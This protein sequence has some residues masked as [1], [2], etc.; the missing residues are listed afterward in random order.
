MSKTITSN[1]YT[2]TG[3]DT[4]VNCN[5]ISGAIVV[6]MPSAREYFDKAITF[7]KTDNTTNTAT[8]DGS[9]ILSFA[10]NYVTLRS[11]G[12]QW[13]VVDTNNTSSVVTLEDFDAVGDGVTNDTEAYLKAIAS[14]AEVRLKEDATYLIDQHSITSNVKITG[15]N[16]TLKCSEA[17]AYFI[18]VSTAVTSLI[19]DG[20]IIDANN[21]NAKCIYIDNADNVKFTNCTFKNA[22]NETEARTAVGIYIRQVTNCVIRDCL[23]TDIEGVPDTVIGNAKGASRGIE[24]NAFTGI[25]SRNITIENNI[26]QN[27]TQDEDGDGI[28]IDFGSAT[29]KTDNANIKIINNTFSNCQ[30]R[31]VKLLSPVGV[32]IEKNSMI[33]D[34]VAGMFSAIGL[35]T[36][37]NVKIV[38][39]EIG[40]ELY[41]TVIETTGTC[42]DV[43]ISN[44]I[45]TPSVE[46]NDSLIELNATSLADF[47]ISNNMMSGA[48]YGVRVKVNATRVIIAGNNMHSISSIPIYIDNFGYDSISNLIITNNTLHGGTYGV[49]VAAGST[50]TIKNNYISSSSTHVL[51]TDGLI[52]IDTDYTYRDRIEIFDDFLGFISGA[53]NLKVGTDGSAKAPEANLVPTGGE[54]VFVTGAAGTGVAADGSIMVGKLPVRTSLDNL[55]FEA[56]VKINTSIAN[57]SVNIGFT[58]NSMGVALEEPFTI[59][60]GDAITSNATDACCFVYDSDADTDQWFA[61]AVDSDVDDTGNATT[62]IAPVAGTWQIFRIETADDGSKVYFYINDVLVST[63]SGGGVGDDVNLYPVI[64]VCSTTTTSK[65]VDVQYVYVAHDRP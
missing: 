53:F 9:N 48:L 6:T 51:V 43:I 64:S 46:P 57:I 50:M 3:T 28:V 18:Y 55:V 16:S 44:N 52:G 2:A 8:I 1:I 11:D 7:K 15:N 42:T 29:D 39:N 13:V 27:I 30:K 63:L 47:I 41:D 20:V 49:R 10:G 26:I 54:A 21:I 31:F 5:A 60:A 23:I 22:F 58:D 14:G 35:L 40:G 36:C 65:T 34:Y 62:G 61:C 59:G 38:N 33:N 56:R 37:S 19:M 4:L 17:E 32:T 25:I 24:I 12:Y 45:I